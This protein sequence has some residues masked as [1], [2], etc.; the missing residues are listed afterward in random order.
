MV[1]AALRRR[2]VDRNS[3]A[4][5]L[6]PFSMSKPPSGKSRSGMGSCPVLASR[7]WIVLATPGTYKVS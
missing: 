3:S 2:S 4:D 5:D 1:R 7:R 6:G